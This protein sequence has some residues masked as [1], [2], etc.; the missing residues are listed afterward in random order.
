MKEADRGIQ[1]QVTLSIALHTSGLIGPFPSGP[2]AEIHQL[3][4]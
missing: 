3:G 1:S 2:S 4:A